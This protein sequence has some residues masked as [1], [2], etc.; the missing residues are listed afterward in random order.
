M[1]ITVTGR[2]LRVW[3]TDTSDKSLAGEFGTLYTPPY[4][5]KVDSLKV[6]FSP[7]IVVTDGE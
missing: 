3:R 7:Y 2:G 1:S 4:R 5:C 6:G